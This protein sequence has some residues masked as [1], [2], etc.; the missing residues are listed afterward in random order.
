MKNSFSRNFDLCLICW[1]AKYELNLFLNTLRKWY[2][3][4]QIMSVKS[5][6]AA[7]SIVTESVN[8]ILTIGNKLPLP[9]DLPHQI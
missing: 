6:M 8:F 1:H 3:T 4:D 7:V 5:N 2:Q 9:W